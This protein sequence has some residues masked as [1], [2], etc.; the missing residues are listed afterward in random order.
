MNNVKVW[1]FENNKEPGLF[2]C[3]GPDCVSDLNDNGD[4]T[5]MAEALVVIRIDLSEPSENDLNQFREMMKGLTFSIDW[6]E[7]VE[8][9]YT[10]KLVEITKA[11]VNEIKDRN[12]W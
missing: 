7:H 5:D 6:A 1:A 3:D 8:P 4:V 10:A 11:Q 9:N 2:L 12:E